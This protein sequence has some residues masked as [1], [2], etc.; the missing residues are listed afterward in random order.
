MFR[1][2][3]VRERFIPAGAGN[4]L[5]LNTPEC[6]K[7]VYPRW[8][9]EHGRRPA[10]ARGWRGLSPLARGTRSHAIIEHPLQRG[11]SPL[12]RGTRNFGERGRQQGR[13][14]PAGAGNTRGSSVI[15][16]MI[17]V[18]PR[19]RGEHSIVSSLF[20]SPPGLSPLARGTRTGA[21]SGGN[22]RRF[23]PAG[24]GNTSGIS[25]TLP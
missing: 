19:W 25:V 3:R 4:T 5:Q 9:G 17:P 14:I 22:L 11:L 6:P 10:V 13:F 18:Y 21:N 20:A 24:A 7:S 2:D 12:A 15:A 23:I 8:R 1:L 16:V